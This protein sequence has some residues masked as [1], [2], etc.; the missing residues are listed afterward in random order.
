MRTALAL[1]VG[2][3]FLASAA[4]AG[5]TKTTVAVECNWGQLTMDQIINNDFPQGPH[6]A[7]P[8]GD[9]V[10][11]NDDDNPR[12]GLANVVNQGDL[13]ALCEFIEDMLGD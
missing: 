5:N 7:D 1:F 8:S 13:Q 2:S 6:S 12:A 9:G 11:P 4:Y 3:F 10:G